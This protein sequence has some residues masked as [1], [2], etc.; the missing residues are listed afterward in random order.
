MVYIVYMVMAYIV[1]VLVGF[2]VDL[3]Q[4]QGL[5]LGRMWAG[6]SCLDI[7]LD[8]GGSG[9]ECACDFLLSI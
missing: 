1:M 4:R 5:G 7:S 2:G 8:L 6:V 3:C 9:S